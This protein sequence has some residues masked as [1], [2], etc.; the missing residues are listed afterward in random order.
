MENAENYKIIGIFDVIVVDIS[1]L[2]HLSCIIIYK[3]LN[4][5]DVVE[6]ACAE[7]LPQFIFTSVS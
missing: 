6:V 7:E 1:V 4:N 3:E 2:E 5:V